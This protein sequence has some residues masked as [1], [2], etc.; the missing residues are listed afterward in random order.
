MYVFADRGVRWYEP[1]TGALGAVV[2]L[3]HR[4]QVKEAIAETLYL[5]WRGLG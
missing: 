3:P 1:Q 2:A 5:P 4:E